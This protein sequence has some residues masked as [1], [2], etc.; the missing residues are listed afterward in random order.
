MGQVKGVVEDIGQYYLATAVAGW[1]TKVS[2]GMRTWP[3]M[4]N[5]GGGMKVNNW[6]ETITVFC[7]Q[8]RSKSVQ[9]YV[10]LAI[11][12]SEF[13]HRPH[14]AKPPSTDPAPPS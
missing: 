14:F 8:S 6:E 4:R 11:L 9:T 2:P 5:K 13:S 3:V 1:P 12:R 7:E 10:V